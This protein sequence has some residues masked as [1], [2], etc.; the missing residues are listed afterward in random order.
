MTVSILTS[1]STQKINNQIR[2]TP[3]YGIA[4][5]PSDAVYALIHAA[6]E[7]IPNLT[8]RQWCRDSESLTFDGFFTANEQLVVYGTWDDAKSEGLWRFLDVV[9]FEPA[10]AFDHV[11]E[12]IRMQRVIRPQSV[13]RIL[14]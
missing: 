11:A 5:A 4:D 10:L 13:M 8:Q 7:T 1:R 12:T 3:I 9:G 6:V 14:V 2:A